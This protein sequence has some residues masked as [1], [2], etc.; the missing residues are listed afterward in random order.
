MICVALLPAPLF[1]HAANALATLDP[2]LFATETLIV[3]VEPSVTIVDGRV[4]PKYMADV[5]DVT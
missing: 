5:S 3:V 2:K 1:G 4:I